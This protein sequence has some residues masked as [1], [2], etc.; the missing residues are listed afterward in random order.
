MYKDFHNN[1]LK[2]YVPLWRVPMKSTL[3][4]RLWMILSHTTEYS[5]ILLLT[6]KQNIYK[7]FDLMDLILTIKPVLE[8][9]DV[10]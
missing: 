1:T 6:T 3:H 8:D 7:N 2:L 9:V 4:E 5:R 10:Q